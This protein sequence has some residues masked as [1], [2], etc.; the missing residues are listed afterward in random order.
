L[1]LKIILICQ[2]CFTAFKK[3]IYSNFL[4]RE[5]VKRNIQQW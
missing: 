3:F 5:S 1:V 4:L 2:F